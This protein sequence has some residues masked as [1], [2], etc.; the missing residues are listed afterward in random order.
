MGYKINRKWIENNGIKKVFN[1]SLFTV[2]T[3][4]L[5]QSGVQPSERLAPLDIMVP[6]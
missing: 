5:Q 1:S 2:H 3:G 4:K 6:N